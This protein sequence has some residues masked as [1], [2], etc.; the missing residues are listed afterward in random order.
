MK[1]MHSPNKID[2]DDDIIQIMST[3]IKAMKNLPKVAVTMLPD[4]CQVLRKNKGLTKELFFLIN[5]YLINS[6]G[7]LE[8]KEENSKSVFKLFKKCFT[9]ES[10][11]KE[12]AFLGTILMQ[13]WVV[14]SK[15]INKETID[16]LLGFVLERT[17]NLYFGVKKDLTNEKENLKDE[18]YLGIALCNLIFSC[19]IK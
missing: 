1:Y 5:L 10:R 17:Q 14:C 2:F 16:S 8:K 4:I 11:H 13:I 12:T 15:E 19:F 9:K 3:L 7:I 6:N 18:D